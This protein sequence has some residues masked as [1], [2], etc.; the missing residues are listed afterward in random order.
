MRAVMTMIWG[1]IFER[2]TIGLS[3]CFLASWVA[4][5]RRAGVAAMSK[6]RMPSGV[7]ASLTALVT[8]GSAPTVPASPTPLM[9]SGSVLAGPV[10]GD[11]E[12]QQI[13]GARRAVIRGRAGEK[14]A[15]CRDRSPRSRVET[16]STH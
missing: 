1:R 4:R 6:R 8:A 12:Q 16:Q 5:H 13:L 10:A 9:P 14:L 3:P 15:R 2:P 11:S 7:S